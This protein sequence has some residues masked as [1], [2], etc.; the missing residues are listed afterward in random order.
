MQANQTFSVGYSL[1]PELNCSVK[2]KSEVAEQ[3]DKF[4]ETLSQ[5]KI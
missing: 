1:A 5:Q 2:W 3:V 4:A